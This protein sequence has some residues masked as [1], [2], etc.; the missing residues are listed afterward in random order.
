LKKAPSTS[1]SPSKRERLARI[2]ARHV[3]RQP[4]KPAQPDLEE[5]PLDDTGDERIP[6]GRLTLSDLADSD[7]AADSY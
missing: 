3:L 4:L 2:R 1:K 7:G 6:L 5:E